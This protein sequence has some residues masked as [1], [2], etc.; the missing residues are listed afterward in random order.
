LQQTYGDRVRVVW[1]DFPLIRIHPQ[2][3]KA[4]E[5]AHCAEEQGKF[6]PYHDLLFANQNALMV[7]DLKNHAQQM[8]LDASRFNACLDSSKYA[9]RVQEGLNAGTALGVSSTPTLFVNGRVM[10]GAYP[11]EELA[12]VVDEELQRK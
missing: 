11:F 12:A 4:A 10:P 9:A 6:W 8:A 3:A 5:A 2:A 1:K 7:D